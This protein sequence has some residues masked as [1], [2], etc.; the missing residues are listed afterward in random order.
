MS[1]RNFPPSFWN[2]DYQP[3]ATKPFMSYGATE[4][5]DYAGLSHH[6]QADPWHYPLTPHHQGYH[7]RPAELSYPPMPS[8][9]R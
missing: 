6:H 5:Y 9:S 3:S 1:T 4:F 8:T 7:H 2:S